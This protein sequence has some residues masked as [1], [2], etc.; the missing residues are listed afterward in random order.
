MSTTYDFLNKVKPK[1][2]II[3]LD[4]YNVYNFPDT[5]V[6]S[7]LNNVNAKVIRTDVNGAVLFTTNGE[8]LVR[9]K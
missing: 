2:A 5:S 4:E 7:I 8:K 9:M 6:V 1:Y 3:S